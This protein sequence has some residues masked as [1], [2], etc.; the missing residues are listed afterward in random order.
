M[1]HGSLWKRENQAEIAQIPGYVRSGEANRILDL[2]AS[3]SRQLRTL[4]IALERRRYANLPNNAAD[5]LTGATPQN[6]E[7]RT[8]DLWSPT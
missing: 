7:P 1:A 2:M 3:I 6:P 4:R 8:R 5:P